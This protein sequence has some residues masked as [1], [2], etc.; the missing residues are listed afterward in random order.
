MPSAAAVAP[1]V[2]VLNEQLETTD[3]ADK[4]AY[5]LYKVA[6]K[7]AAEANRDLQAVTSALSRMSAPPNL[8][9]DWP[10]AVALL[11]AFADFLKQTPR[12]NGR[13]K[14]A[15]WRH[16][17]CRWAP[18]VQNALRSA[19]W[20]NPSLGRADAVGPFVLA[21]MIHAVTGEAVAA[22]TVARYLRSADGRQ[23]MTAVSP[24]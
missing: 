18:M 8:D 16:H 19:G 15:P 11:A 22:A 9:A 23:K 10:Q 12:H 3:A 6:L 21:R 5:R 24:P 2:A 20:P 1:L 4:E 7:S 17:A 14:G 13:P